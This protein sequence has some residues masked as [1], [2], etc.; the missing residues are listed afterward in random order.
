MV[1]TSLSNMQ[2]LVSKPQAIFD[3]CG[4]LAAPE[5]SVDH[6][7]DCKNERAKRYGIILP[8]YL[9]LVNSPMMQSVL[10]KFVADKEEAEVA[11]AIYKAVCK[12]SGSGQ[13]GSGTTTRTRWTRTGFY[14]RGKRQPQKCYSCSQPGHFSRNCTKKD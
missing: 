1:E 5:Q 7:R 8:Q 6:A 14:N 4:A 13:S 11:K 2:L 12:R 10:I 9:P 3:L